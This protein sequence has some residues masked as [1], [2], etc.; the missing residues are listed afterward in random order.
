M[1]NLTHVQAFLAIVD[2]GGFHEAARRL[3]ASQPTVSQQ[4][5]KLEESLGVTLVHRAHR[6]ASPTARG[7]AFLPFARRLIEGAE[8]SIQ[9]VHRHPL[10][11]GAASNP[12]IYLLPPYI[13]RFEQEDPKAL[14]VRLRIGTNPETIARLESGEIDVAVTEWW[15]P[16]SGCEVV[17]WRRD[18]MVVIVAPD[19]RWSRRRSISAE[20]F[21]TEPVL[22]GEPGTG[23]GRLLRSELRSLVD[24]MNVTQQLGS[25]EAVKRAVAAGLGISIVLASAVRDE[26]ASGSLVALTLEGVSMERQLFVITPA[27]APPTAMSR[28]FTAT[29]MQLAS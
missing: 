9:A 18:P 2:S 5:R 26:V 15:E 17:P 14:P 29:L 1:L 8:R 12:G 7:A 3:G 27:D 19:H 24:R 22:G 10:A 16:R 13:R 28:R 11:V 23:T 4:L 20:E 25:T 6:N 21:V